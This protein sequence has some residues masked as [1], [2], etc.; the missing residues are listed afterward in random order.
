M[1]AAAR[2]GASTGSTLALAPC[3]SVSENETDDTSETTVATVCHVWRATARDTNV[4][5]GQAKFNKRRAATTGYKAKAARLQR[6]PSVV[7]AGV[8]SVLGICI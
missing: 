1:V 2:D 7:P 8:L 6:A 5:Q 3:R 4:T